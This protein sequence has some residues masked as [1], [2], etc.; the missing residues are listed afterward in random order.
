MAYIIVSNRKKHIITERCLMWKF[1]VELL[2]KVKETFTNRVTQDN[3][4][5]FTA[6]YSC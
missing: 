2:R 1:I 4:V 6:D 5:K 3:S